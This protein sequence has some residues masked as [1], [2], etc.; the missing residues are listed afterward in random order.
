MITKQVG[1]HSPQKSAEISSLVVEARPESVKQAR[2]FTTAALARA[3]LDPTSVYF[4]ATI[5]TEL[6]TNAYKHGSRPGDPITVRAYLAD[7]GPVLEV[8]DTSDAPPVAQPFDLERLSGRGLLLVSEMVRDW[9]FTP[10]APSGKAVW[11]V[12][13]ESYP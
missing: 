12:L 5:A 9:G 1:P 8:W 13:R 4:A 2:D 7:A 11:A 10:L 3:G 6:V